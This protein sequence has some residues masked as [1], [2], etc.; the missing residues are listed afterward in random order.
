MS[1]LLWG[2][3]EY[4]AKTIEEV[5]EAFKEDTDHIQEACGVSLDD[6]VVLLKLYKYVVS[7]QM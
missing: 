5:A 6:S 4:C 3:Q 7:E 2:R 1:T